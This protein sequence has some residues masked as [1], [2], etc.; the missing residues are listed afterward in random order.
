MSYC[1]RCGAKAHEDERYCVSCGAQLPEDIHDRFEEQSEPEGFNRWWFAPISVLIFTLILSIALHLYLEYQE[2]QAVDAYKEGVELALDG[3]FNNAKDKFNESLDY[4]SNYKAA[5]N[6]LEFIDVAIN[7]QKSLNEIDKLV[8]AESYQQAMNLTND[9]ESQL[10]HYNG[11]VVNHLLTNIVDKRN[12]IKVAQVRSQ[13]DEDNGIDELKMQLWQIESIDNEEAEELEKQMKER[14]VNYSFNHANEELNENHFSSA[15]AIVKDA[16]RFVPD[17]E[18]LESLKTTIEKQQVAF[19]TEQNKRIEQALNQYEIEQ[20]NNA[21]D[22]VEV[23]SIDVT[24]DEEDDNQIIVS[25]ELKSVATVP[26]Y[27][28]SVKYTLH[29]EDGEQILENETFLYPD[30]LYPEETGEFEYAHYDIEED[31]EITVEQIKWYLE[32]Q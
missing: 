24:R 12:E 16:L 17:N 6:S 8:D 32:G 26:I 10:N 18:K 20:E 7:V 5:S 14:I 29:N 27:S 3:Q 1:P 25:G 11:E 19:E 23:V 28:L 2:D 15:L 9:I 31:V 21:N 30:T 13:L 4:K 22:A